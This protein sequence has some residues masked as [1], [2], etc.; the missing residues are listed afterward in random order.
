LQIPFA[1]T[2]TTGRNALFI[3]TNDGSNPFGLNVNL[4]GHASNNNR[5]VTLSAT[6]IGATLEVLQLSALRYDFTQTNDSN[7][8]A[9]RLSPTSTVTTLEALP[10]NAGVHLKP[11]GSGF[12]QLGASTY[13]TSSFSIYL[14]YAYPFSKTD[15]TARNVAFFGSNDASNPFGLNMNVTGNATAASRIFKLGLGAVGVDEAGILQFAATRVEALCPFVAV[16]ATTSI[17]SIRLPH[18]AAPSSPTDGDMWTTTAGL[19]VRINGATV[20][21][22]S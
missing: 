5:T 10:S 22:L 9:A 8:T 15:G 7:V 14:Q 19:Y 6:G 12:I 1:K 16:A 3:G 18:G 21:P 4:L 13:S 20:G 11:N 17:P 2:D